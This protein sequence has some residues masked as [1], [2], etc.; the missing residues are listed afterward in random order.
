MWQGKNGTGTLCVYL[1]QY[2]WRCGVLFL[3]TLYCCV[4]SSVA[5]AH[6]MHLCS[7]Q[8][9]PLETRH[10]DH[11]PY[12][13]VLPGPP[14]NTPRRVDVRGCHSTRDHSARQLGARGP[15][16]PPACLLYYIFHLV[17]VCCPRLIHKAT[18]YCPLNRCIYRI[19]HCIAAYTILHRC[20]SNIAYC[21]LHIEYCILS[22]RFARFV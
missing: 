8:T 1:H 7:A 20:I 4:L 2:S 13:T 17:G 16:S 15:P 19:L 9:P 5:V 14:R 3:N 6:P 12:T 10:H 18:S 22:L 21:I 11:S